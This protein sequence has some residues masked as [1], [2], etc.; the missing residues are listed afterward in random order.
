MRLSL[1]S[2]LSNTSF[3]GVSR[4]PEES[5]DRIFTPSFATISKIVNLDPSPVGLF[6]G[7]RSR[8]EDVQNNNNSPLF[9]RVPSSSTSP[10]AAI[11][12][13]SGTYYHHPSSQP[14][15][16]HHHHHHFPTSTS[17]KIRTPIPIKF[18]LPS[19]SSEGPPHHQGFGPPASGNK[20]LVPSSGVLPNPGVLLSP[21]VMLA[22]GWRSEHH[23]SNGLSSMTPTSP[24]DDMNGSNGLPG[25]GQT[26]HPPQPTSSASSAASPNSADKGQ[27]IECVVCGDKSSGK[28]YGVSTCE[29]CKSF[30]KR[31][32]RRN[33]TYS[34]RGNRNCPIDQHHRNQ[35]QY[36]RL[37]KCL[38][39]GMQRTEW[40]NHGISIRRDESHSSCLAGCG[41]SHSY[42]EAELR[43]IQMLMEF[44]KVTPEE[45]SKAKASLCRLAV[46]RGRVPPTPGPG[47]YPGQLALT[48]G[49]GLNGP[50]YLSSY[51]SLLLRAE[52]YPTS[53]YGQCMQANNIMGID[54]I[55]ELA[56]RLLFSAV[57]W[58]RNIPF[59]PDLQVTDQVALLRLVWSEL[60][61][62]N[63][64]QCSM[65]LHV[66]PLLAAA[67][68]HAAPMAADRVV[69]FMDHIR[70]FQEQ[71]EKLKA[72]HVDSAE[73][74]CLKAIV[75]FTT[76]A[77]GLS[78]V[79]HIEGLQEKSQCALEEY[80]RTQYPNQPTRFGKL[81]LRLPSLRTV[82]SQVVIEKLFFVR[83]VGA[84]QIETLIRDMLLSGSSFNWPYVNIQHMTDL[85]LPYD[86]P[87]PRPR[88]PTTDHHDQQYVVMKGRALR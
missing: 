15:H 68:L 57:E 59:F 74:S 84:T 81:L 73:Y 34:C 87:R 78:D 44:L 52:P 28:H 18:D 46:Q 60:F 21:D 16:H 55:C 51:I 3:E 35:C 67:G 62:L 71:V 10:P 58:A 83:L 23:P 50:T 72:L 25:L 63:A 75:L 86:C 66:A 70:I 39:M 31:S 4:R 61:V 64:S 85:C 7:R 49:D 12:N 32:V 38:K 30:F 88:C 2:L 27:N 13:Y 17:A 69:A 43:L 1:T 77:C 45:R 80:C 11:D 29:G 82:S 6:W 40:L 79:N 33:L 56:A 14:G 22:S 20:V 5:D 36:C 41:W 54:N 37:K 24:N 42:D 53:R 47:G 9:S 48:N 19:W 8:P 76:D 26:T 65:P